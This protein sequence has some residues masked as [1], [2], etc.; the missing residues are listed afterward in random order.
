[1]PAAKPFRQPAATLR[2]PPAHDFVGMCSLH[3]V[4][5]AMASAR[6]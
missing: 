2:P 3:S 5:A 1:M 4:P 6:R